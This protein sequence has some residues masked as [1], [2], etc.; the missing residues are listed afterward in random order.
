MAT[1]GDSVLTVRELLETADEARLRFALIS[2]CLLYPEICPT[3]SVQL[4][5]ATSTLRGIVG[6]EFESKFAFVKR[7]DTIIEGLLRDYAYVAQYFVKILSQPPMPLEFAHQLCGLRF[8]RLQRALSLGLKSKLTLPCTKKLRV[9]QG[10][11]AACEIRSGSQLLALPVELLDMVITS[12][13]DLKPMRLTSRVF[14]ELILEHSKFSQ[15]RLKAHFWFDDSLPRTVLKSW[16]L[17][18]LRQI[19][20]TVI[21]EVPR[22]RR[23]Y[24][25]PNPAWNRPLQDDTTSVR[26]TMNAR[27]IR[28]VLE[29]ITSLPNLQ[30]LSLVHNT[31]RAA[32]GQS[33][34]GLPS[35]MPEKHTCRSNL[36]DDLL[37][38][39]GDVIRMNIKHGLLGHSLGLAKTQA[40][41][42]VDRYVFQK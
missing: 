19:T 35:W 1:R 21:L 9:T 27:R 30:H 11:Q 6:R 29:L 24:S 34:M 5:Y 37:A 26:D 33:H 20:S 8:A 42:I 4:P 18:V 13:S 39:L 41:G 7:P 12:L 14:K 36:R 3:T 10:T 40:G 38:R 28:L 17:P 23:F 32:S 22:T 15:Q 2:A 16:K 31:W 25:N